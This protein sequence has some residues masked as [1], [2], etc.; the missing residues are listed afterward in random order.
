MGVFDFLREIE[1]ESGQLLEP[2]PEFDFEEK[3]SESLEQIDVVQS[4]E[5]TNNLPLETQEGK[6]IFLTSNSTKMIE[7]DSI[8]LR[9]FCVHESATEKKQ[10]DGGCDSQSMEKGCLPDIHKNEDKDFMVL[11]FPDFILEDKNELDGES[12]VVICTYMM[13]C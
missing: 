2:I 12:N 7:S 11:R 13:I 1:V 4:T 9:S 10:V 5:S 6:D 8:V 3:V